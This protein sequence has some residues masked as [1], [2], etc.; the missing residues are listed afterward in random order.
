MV[1][2]G[3]TS[4][5]RSRLRDVPSVAADPSMMSRDRKRERQRVCMAAWLVGVTVREY[6][7]MEAGERMPDP[8]TWERMVEVFQWPVALA[9]S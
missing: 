9:C 3:P 2:D 8:S 6:R 1:E 5:K 4:Q 7:E